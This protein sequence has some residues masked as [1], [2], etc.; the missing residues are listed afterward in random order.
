MRV[1]IA[2]I[3]ISTGCESKR[4]C[5]TPGPYKVGQQVL[6]R[7]DVYEGCKGYIT[8]PIDSYISATEPCKAR[9]SVTTTE[10]NG[11]NM[12]INLTVFFDGLTLK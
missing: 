1:F 5:Y 7:S 4:W 2:L 6:I 8:S 3:L 10:C 9:Y 11:T 12:S